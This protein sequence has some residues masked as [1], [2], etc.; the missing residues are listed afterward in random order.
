LLVFVVAFSIAMIGL[1]YFGNN[2]SSGIA[3]L[4]IFATI[5]SYF[6][7]CGIVG[8]LIGALH[9]SQNSSV[10]ISF[11]FSTYSGDIAMDWSVRDPLDRLGSFSERSNI[12]RKDSFLGR[13]LKGSFF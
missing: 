1:L 11:S 5:P 7:L 2:S 13:I 6:L 8:I 12:L 3:I 9:P 10:S 4:A